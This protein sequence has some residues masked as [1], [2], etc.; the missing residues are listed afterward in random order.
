MTILKATLNHLEELA[1]LFDG[2]RVFYKQKSDL[3]A[4]KVFLKERL[5]NN[6][7]EIFMAYIDNKA[8][9]FTQLYPLFSS[10]S[11]TPMYLLNDLYVD[12]LYRGN[13]IGIALI[14][15]AKLMSVKMNLKGLA[16]QTAF[17]NPAQHLYER[18]GFTK[19][20][21]LHF[22]WSNEKQVKK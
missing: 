18:L 20:S 11:M 13:G 7:S 22:F 2:Y 17:D 3:E 15:R 10:V 6:D 12:L 5:T 21:D 1:L 4:A 16:I 8:V 14:K 19:D 9:G